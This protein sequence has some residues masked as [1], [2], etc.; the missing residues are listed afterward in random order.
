MPR[1]IQG[2]YPSYFET[3]IAVVPEDNV[4]EALKAQDK[5]INEFLPGIAENKH[6]FAYAPGKWTLKEMLQHIIDTE[7][8]FQ[9]RALCFARQEK[10]SLPGF[11][12]NDYAAVSNANARNWQSLCSELKLLR[13]STLLMYESFSEE[14]LAQAGMANR[15]AFSCNAIGFCIAGH[16]QHHKNIIE[17]RY[18]G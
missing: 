6:E 10:Q 15:K 14:M 12:E 8:I 7:R 3:Y 4:L 1:P 16:L 2:T 9:Y 5:L 13:Q 18:L 17:E 11:E